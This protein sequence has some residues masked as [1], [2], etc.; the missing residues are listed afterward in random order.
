M[1]R[2]YKEPTARLY[3]KELKRNGIPIQTIYLLEANGKQEGFISC[4]LEGARTKMQKLYPASK[5]HMETLPQEAKFGR[6]NTYE[7]DK[8]L[9]EIDSLTQEEVNFDL[10][11]I[12]SAI[13]TFKSKRSRLIIHN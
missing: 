3:E 9:D 8:S 2:D 6:Y 1:E 13:N 5:K 12:T 10:E 11:R 4:P 7:T